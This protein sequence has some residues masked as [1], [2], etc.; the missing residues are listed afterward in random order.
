MHEMTLLASVAQII[1]EEMEKHGMTRLVRV[2]L[3]S[4]ALAGLA[5]EAMH[6]AWEVI[7]ESGPLKGAELCVEQT[8]VRLGCGECGREFAPEQQVVFAPC[9]GCGAELG[10]KVLEGREVY[11]ESIEGEDGVDDPPDD[12]PDDATEGMAKG[13]V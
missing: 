12:A 4:G 10:H 1:Q 9:P 5:P 7:T 2:V 8:A 6:F 13:M 3:K 11:V